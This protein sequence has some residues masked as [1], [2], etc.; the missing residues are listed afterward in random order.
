MQH[1][2]TSANL[3]CVQLT[4]VD[5]ASQL[6][7]SSSCSSVGAERIWEAVLRITESMLVVAGLETVDGKSLLTM[8]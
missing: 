8:A 7:Q 2:S 3:C 4:R 6:S 1:F 5:S